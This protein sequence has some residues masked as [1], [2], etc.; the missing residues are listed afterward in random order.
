MRWPGD[1]ILVEAGAYAGCGFGFL[2][3]DVG[4]KCGILS[5]SP[6]PAVAAQPAGD[7]VHR[8]FRAVAAQLA[9]IHRAWSEWGRMASCRLDKSA[10]DI[11]HKR[12]GRMP[13]C[14]T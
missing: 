12:P 9:K 8:P 11:A 6:L 3:L 2:R 7:W 4:R 10:S 5:A 1:T 13:S 14:P